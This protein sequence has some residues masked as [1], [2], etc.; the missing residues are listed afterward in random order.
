MFVLMCNLTSKISENHKKKIQNNVFYIEVKTICI[1][2]DSQLLRNYK[3]HFT[4]ITFQNLIFKM[5][6]QSISN[7]QSKCEWQP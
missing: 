3:Q 2:S 6:Q 5:L 4:F 1:A 7:S